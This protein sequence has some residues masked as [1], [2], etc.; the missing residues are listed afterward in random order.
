MPSV[1]FETAIPEIELLQSYALDRTATGLGN[2]L[3]ILRVNLPDLIFSD[4]KLEELLA[5]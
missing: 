4:W 2:G 1:R 5:N 3:N